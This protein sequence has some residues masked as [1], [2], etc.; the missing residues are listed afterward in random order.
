MF[1]RYSQRWW[2]GLAVALVSAC[3]DG[4]PDR[5][6]SAQ[7]LA[8][9]QLP[10]NVPM[11][12][13][14]GLAASFGNVG[15]VDLD[16][17]FFT[18]QGTNGRHCGTCHTPVDGWSIT[19]ATV[20]ALFQATGGTHPIFAAHLDTDT[21][22][23]DMSTAQARWNAT[24]MLRQGKFTRR[25]APPE[26]RDYDVIAANDPFGVGTVSS[27]FW[28]RRPLVTATFRSPTVMWDGAN[29]MGTDLHTGLIKQ[30]RGN[31]TGA[32]QGAPAPDVV[33]DETVEYQL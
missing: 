30:A 13:A 5:G 14:R 25:M 9:Q 4:A 24:T 31:V 11:P 20:T 19:G 15:Y 2:C 18:P 7:G 21:P 26:I 8:V 16:N 1:D 6:V 27:L 23:A 12:N 33:V 10:N 17:A 22:A 32:Q 29:T 3:V 28:F